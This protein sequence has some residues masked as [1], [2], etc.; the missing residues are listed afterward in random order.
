MREGLFS[1]R[2]APV[3]VLSSVVVLG[4]YVA[5]FV[6]A[7]EVAGTGASVGELVPLAVLALLAMGLPLNVG[8]GGLGRGSPPGRS[9]RRGWGPGGG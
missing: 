8:G 2:S 5:M 4:G 6:L 7:A 1:R 3:V 9:G